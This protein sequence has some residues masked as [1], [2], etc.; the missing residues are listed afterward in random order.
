MIE[1]ILSTKGCEILNKRVK[2]KRKV[3]AKKAVI[4][5]KYPSASIL[6]DVSLDEYAKERERTNTIESKA[7]AFI[8]VIIALFTIYIPIIPFSKLSI[9]YS[10]FNK[11]GIACLTV[12]LC[13]MLLSVIL[14]IFAFA[15]LYKAYKVKGYHRVEFSSLNDDNILAQSENNVKRALV[16]H[17]NTILVGNAK[18]NT[19]KAEAVAAGIKYSIIAFALLSLSSITLIIM[20]GGI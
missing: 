11:P 9:A 10:S 15:N 17:Y 14:L 12:T 20:I 6:L 13:V 1:C 7:N 8:S 2:T 5:N 4:Q 18:I 3:K 16:D 19:E